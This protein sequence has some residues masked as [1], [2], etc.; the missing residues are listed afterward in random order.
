M[1]SQDMVEKI[2][3]IQNRRLKKELEFHLLG[4]WK[5]KP[6]FKNANQLQIIDFDNKKVEFFLKTS[7]KE[8][9]VSIKINKSYP[10]RTPTVYLNDMPYDKILHVPPKFL[11]NIGIY[12]ECMCCESILCHWGLKCDLCNI[13]DEVRDNLEIRTRI[14]HY[15]FCEKWLKKLFKGDAFPHIQKHIL[16]FI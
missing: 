6:I 15:I 13:M 7:T 1:N 3:S 12:Y 11:R 10:W 16:T 2:N 14:V 4:K 5:N 9:F 8:V